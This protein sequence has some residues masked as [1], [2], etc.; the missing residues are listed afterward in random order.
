MRF[1]DELGGVGGAAPMKKTA[2]AA[3]VQMIPRINTW[4]KENVRFG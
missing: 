3:T 2:G 1:A 4:G